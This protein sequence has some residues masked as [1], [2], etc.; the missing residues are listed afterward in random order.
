MGRVFVEYNLEIIGP[1]KIGRENDIFQS[2]YAN[3]CGIYIWAIKVKDKYIINYIGETGLSFKKRTKEHLI[4]LI[5]GNYRVPEPKDLCVGKETIL[6]DGLWRKGQ[7]DK[8]VEFIKIYE[9]LAPKIKEYIE[10]LNIF[11]IPM[12]VEARIRKL[13]EGNI[14][15]HVR[16]QPFY[17]SGLLPDDIRYITEK[18]IDEQSFSVKLLSSEKILGL[19]EKI[20]VG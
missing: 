6:W 13:I 9:S 18:K 20:Q 14:A 1:Y 7:R 5:G 15:K 19:P 12:D 16:N 4:Q 2:P 10:M 11:L 3:Q 17:I 8:I